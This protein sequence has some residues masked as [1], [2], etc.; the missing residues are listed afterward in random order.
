MAEEHF[1]Y[2]PRCNEIYSCTADRPVDATSHGGPEDSV[3]FH[4]YGIR[5]DT[6]VREG[7]KATVVIGG[8]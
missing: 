7:E 8:Y 2:C 4:H 1:H 3:C 6:C 5:H